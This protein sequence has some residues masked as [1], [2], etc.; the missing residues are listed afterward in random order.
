MTKKLTV[1]N[2][3]IILVT[4][5][6]IGFLVFFLLY[7]PKPASIVT[8]DINPSIELRLDTDNKIIKAIPINDDAKKI[9]ND[10]LSGKTLDEAINIIFNNVA[11]KIETFDNHIV[12]LVNTTGNLDNDYVV[13]RIEDYSNNSILDISVMRVE[14]ITEEDKK[15]AKKYNITEAKASLLN[16]LKIDY[17]NIDLDELVNKDI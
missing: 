4:L 14:E 16:D 17:P 13:K 11:E 1:V 12:V 9:I 2:I 7:T 10:D 3:L 8:L 5:I 6:I 15:I